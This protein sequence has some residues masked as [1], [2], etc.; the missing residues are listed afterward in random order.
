ML[1]KI[2]KFIGKKKKIFFWII[3]AVAF[4][5]ISFGINE[6]GET[7]DEIA[8][9]NA[10]RQYISSIYHG[11]FKTENWNANKEHHKKSLAARRS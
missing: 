6:T 4:L 7:W 3:L 9:Y 10:G 2:D 11:R 5:I 1:Q 8:Y